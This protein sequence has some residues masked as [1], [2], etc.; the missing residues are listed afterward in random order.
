MSHGKKQKMGDA[1]EVSGHDILFFLKPLLMG[2][3]HI[4]RRFLNGSDNIGHFLHA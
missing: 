2:E 3:G 1:S 4:S